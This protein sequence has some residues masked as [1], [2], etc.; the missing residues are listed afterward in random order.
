M[1]WRTR[2][3]NTKRKKRIERL[4]QKYGLLDRREEIN[5]VWGWNAQRRKVHA[6]AHA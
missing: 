4:M 3:L 5:S 6:L 2:K 1:Y